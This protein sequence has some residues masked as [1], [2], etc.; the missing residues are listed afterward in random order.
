MSNAD[1]LKTPVS[2][3]LSIVDWLTLIG[4]ASAHVNES[5]SEMTI[6]C[7]RQIGKQVQA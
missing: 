3:Q 2:V 7:I 1:F 4:W 5:T 6:A